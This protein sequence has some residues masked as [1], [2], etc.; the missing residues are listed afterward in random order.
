MIKIDNPTSRVIF[1][2][3][4]LT[5]VRITGLVRPSVRLSVVLPR[6]QKGVEKPKMARKF[7]R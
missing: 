5:V 4:E 7:P 3:A 1:A 6:K 2:V